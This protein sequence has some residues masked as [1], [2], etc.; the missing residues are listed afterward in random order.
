MPSGKTGEQGSRYSA[1]GYR[2]SAVL[3]DGS[4]YLA[5]AALSGAANS[6]KGTFSAWLRPDADGAEMKIFNGRQI[7]AGDGTF[8]VS[9]GASNRL[10]ILASGENSTA[11]RLLIHT[12]QTD[13]VAANG[14]RHMAASWDMVDTGKRHF[15]LDG[16]E[17]ISVDT[18]ADYALD[19]TLDTWNVGRDTFYTS[20]TW[21]GGLADVIWWP[22][23]YVDLSVAANL[24]AFYRNGPVSPSRALAL[25]GAPIVD[26]RG[27]LP[28]W[29]TNKG[30][31]GAFTETGTLTETIF[32]P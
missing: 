29:K 16:V 24:K 31:G 30:S 12:T 11:V 13:I 20:Q 1:I 8:L 9:R 23:V 14:W 4:S 5:R 28:G 25:L 21:Q 2:P 18:W 26:F 10:S 6:K 27:D 22:G 32:K 3:F 19:Y 17:D 7:G 15:I